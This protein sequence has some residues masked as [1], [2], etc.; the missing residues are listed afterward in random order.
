MGGS[1]TADCAD[2][3]CGRE[4]FAS[5]VWTS[6][7]RWCNSIGGRVVNG[8]VV[9]RELYCPNCGLLQVWMEG[10]DPVRGVPNGVVVA[11]LARTA[12]QDRIR[13][14]WRKLEEQSR[15]TLQLG[16]VPA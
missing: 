4:F 14:F 15:A 5:D 2:R 1:T 9:E 11:L 7:T 3:S 16:E 6:S 12:D 10:W 13:D 8:Q